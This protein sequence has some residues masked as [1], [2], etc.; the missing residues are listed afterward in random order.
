[1][2]NV[3]PLHIS[4]KRNT[5]QKPPTGKLSPRSVAKVSMYTPEQRARLQELLNPPKTPMRRLRDTWEALGYVPGDMLY[6]VK[7][8]LGMVRDVNKPDT[9]KQSKNSI[10][11]N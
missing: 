5:Q 1:M 6:A 3:G 8:K 7:K 4:W 10:E 2:I 11:A 9:P